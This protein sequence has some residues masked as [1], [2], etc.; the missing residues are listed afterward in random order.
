M[1]KVKLLLQFILDQGV[2]SE[3]RADFS[4]FEVLEEFWR[5][6]RGAEARGVIRY[7]ALETSLA[8]P[9]GSETKPNLALRPKRNLKNQKNWAFFDPSRPKTAQ[10]GLGYQWSATGPILSFC[11]FSGPKFTILS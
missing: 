11:I 4:I 10:N 1:K 5:G 7:F 8:N 9:P 2:D 3:K 6:P